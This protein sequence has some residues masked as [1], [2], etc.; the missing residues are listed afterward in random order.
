MSTYGESIRIVY[1]PMTMQQ[2]DELS[3]MSGSHDLHTFFLFACITYLILASET[4]TFKVQTHQ[5]KSFA[6]TYKTRTLV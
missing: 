2:T 4:N 3:K 5:C 1:V 6:C